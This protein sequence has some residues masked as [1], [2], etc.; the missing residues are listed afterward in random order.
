MKEIKTTSH[1]MIEVEMRK[2]CQEYKIDTCEVVPFDK[3]FDIN[4][5][6]GARQTTYKVYNAILDRVS[7][8]ASYIRNSF[9]EKAY[10][11]VVER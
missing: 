4:L 1:R 7:S 5:T 11:W 8:G 3:G 9:N 2:I 6:K 10:S